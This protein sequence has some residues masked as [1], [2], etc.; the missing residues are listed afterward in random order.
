MHRLFWA[1]FLIFRTFCITACTADNM[2]SGPLKTGMP[3]PW[4]E[5]DKDIDCAKRAAGFDFKVKAQDIKIRAMKDMIEI[6]YP[7]DENR[8]VI[9]RKT[10][11]ELYNKTDISGDYNKYP[12]MD[13]I[14]LDNGVEFLTRR[15]ENLIYVAYFG[16]EDGFYSINCA[17]GMTKKE[18][19]E[20]YKI[21]ALGDF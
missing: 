17:K 10:T 14:I 2:P 16:A 21:I 12:I 7:L 4:I 15:D 19:E 3:N 6:N 11:E 9:I 13:K 20:I 5:C 18:L 1:I 8:D